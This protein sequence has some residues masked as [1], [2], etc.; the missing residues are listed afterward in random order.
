MKDLI[1]KASLGLF[2]TGMLII[3]LSLCAIPWPVNV[4]PNDKECFGGAYMDY[5]YDGIDRMFH[6][7]CDIAC[8]QEIPVI[9]TSSNNGYI[10]GI[11][12]D[13][14]NPKFC[15]IS[16]KETSDSPNAWYYGHTTHFKKPDGT[17]WKKD[18]PV[19]KNDRLAKTVDFG[20]ANDHLEF[21]KWKNTVDPKGIHI[22]LLNPLQVLD[23]YEDNRDPVIDE[24]KFYSE[25]TQMY[26]NNKQLRGKI[27]IIV[28]ASDQTK[29]FWGE[30][31]KNDAGIYKIGY[32]ILN[33]DKTQALSSERILMEA[34][35][36]QPPNNLIDVVY[37][38]GL[39]GNTDFYYI[40]TNTDNDGVVEPSDRNECWDTTGISDGEY[41]IRVKAW[42]VCGNCKTDDLT[43]AV[44]NRTSMRIRAINRE[45][46]P[47]GGASIVVK[48]WRGEVVGSGTTDSNGYY[49]IEH[50][51][52]ET[53]SIEVSKD[54]YT[55][56]QDVPFNVSWNYTNTLD[57]TIERLGY[58]TGTVR[59]RATGANI[60]GAKVD[61]G[62]G[63]I[64]YTNNHGAYKFSLPPG[65][66]N[67]TASCVNYTSETRYGVRV[68]SGEETQLNFELSPVP[69]AKPTNLQA[70]AISDDKI[71]LSWQDNSN[72]E[73]GFKIER[74]IMGNLY[75]QITTVAED[76]TTYPSKGRRCNIL[77]FKK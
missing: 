36:E 18:D 31:F 51:A 33:K 40:L 13:P 14:L 49:T 22:G 8:G 20:I 55:S 27:D 37:D 29:W 7:G 75:S 45:G 6:H 9:Y 47:V 62:L 67:V 42:D 56:V 53:Y 70:T 1:K 59:N 41:V 4:T 24:W 38:I 17:D 12:I 21:G 73:D 60:Q 46:N 11:Y 30:W 63:Y 16:V 28:K 2:L 32:Q 54:G 74:K 52:G 44:T 10:A 72:N 39:S 58:I 76:V 15:W 48:D 25:D 5:R 50:I 34:T 66:Y 69:L 77:G 68:R 61:A 57:I 65:D 43:V 23:D 19:S 26:M 3:P 35:E 71:I 64:A